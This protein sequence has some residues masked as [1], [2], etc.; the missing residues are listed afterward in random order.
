VQRVSRRNGDRDPESLGNPLLDLHEAK[1]IRHSRARVVVDEQIEVTIASVG[2]TSP[3][4]E[5]D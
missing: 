2:V 1:E 3:R 5:N 4:P